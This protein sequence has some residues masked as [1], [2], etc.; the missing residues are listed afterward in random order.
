LF[1]N[2]HGIHVP[3]EVQSVAVKLEYRDFLIVGILAAGLDVTEN[4]SGGLVKD[5]W[6]YIQDNK[7]KAGRIQVF[8]NWSPFMVK[9]PDTVWLGVEYFCN[10]TDDFWQKSDNEIAAI[11]VKEMETI[12]I[13]HPAQVKDTMVARIKKAYPSYYGSYEYFSRVQHFS[14]TIENL[15]LIGRNGMHRYNNS[16]HSMLTAMAAVENIINGRKD[17][18]NIWEINT[19]ETYHEEKGE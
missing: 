16:D 5:N 3:E 10:E 18:T 6:I 2:L 13:L 12:G 7:V 14:D 19:E 8:N 17:K 15:F 11:A 4:D 9:D 1:E